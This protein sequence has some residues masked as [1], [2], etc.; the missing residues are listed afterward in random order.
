MKPLFAAAAVAL[1]LAAPAA[2]AKKPTTV[3]PI[4]LY[5]Y[6]YAPAPITLRA[7][8]PVTMVFTNRSDDRHEFK[9]PAF[10]H[11]AK[12]LSGKVH[13]GEIHLRPGQSTSVTLIPARGSY[14]VHCS[15]FFH[16]QL[17][18]ETRLYVQ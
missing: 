9:A 16:T 14:R 11:A 2:A 4:V 15:H 5:S 1:V 10:F 18:M 6:G 8:R 7:G 12:I 13:E 17:G 3:V